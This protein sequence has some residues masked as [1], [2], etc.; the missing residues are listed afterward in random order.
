MD[1]ETKEYL[2]KKMAE[3]RRK[4]IRLKKFT[5]KKNW[6]DF[7]AKVNKEIKK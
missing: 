4:V 5:K 6:K 7:R 2:A 3:L 1:K